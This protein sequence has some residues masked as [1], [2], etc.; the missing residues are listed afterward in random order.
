MVLKKVAKTDKNYYIKFSFHANDAAGT[1]II[2][3]QPT[4]THQLDNNTVETCQT[5]QNKFPPERTPYICAF[6]IIECLQ[7]SV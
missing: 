2:H 5:L 3:K 4:V 1:A 6:I 7:K